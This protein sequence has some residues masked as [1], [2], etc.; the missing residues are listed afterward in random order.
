MFRGSH[1]RRAFSVRIAAS[2]LKVKDNKER[3]PA[4]ELIEYARELD[5]WVLNGDPLPP[6]TD[7]EKGLKAV[8]HLKGPA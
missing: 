1:D 3:V 5:A 7:R 8:S 2:M 4:T 6:A